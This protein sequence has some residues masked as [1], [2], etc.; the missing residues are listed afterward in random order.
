LRE[1]PQY[2]E[3][4]KEMEIAAAYYHIYESRKKGNTFVLVYWFYNHKICG[5]HGRPYRIT[6]Y[7]LSDPWLHWQKAEP[8]C[9]E[10][11]TREQEFITTL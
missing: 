1:A 9:G 8:I 10:I 6:S 3:P 11:Y 2:S 5:M 7:T 4:I